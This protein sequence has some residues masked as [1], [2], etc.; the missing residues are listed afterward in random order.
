MSCSA[1]LDGK[2]FTNLLHST[3][4]TIERQPRLS[5]RVEDPVPTTNSSHSGYRVAQKGTTEGSPSSIALTIPGQLTLAG[6]VE[7]HREKAG[8]TGDRFLPRKHR[9][10]EGQTVSTTS[11]AVQ[12]Q[13]TLSERVDEFMKNHSFSRDDSLTGQKRNLEG[14]GDNG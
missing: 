8:S 12:R 6:P 14:R 9:N 5:R 13:L 7:E 2:A 1:G 10:T 4:C 11:T 3:E